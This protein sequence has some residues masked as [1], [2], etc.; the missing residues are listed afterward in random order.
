MK[1]GRPYI[2]RAEDCNIPL[3][4]TYEFTGIT[5]ENAT[6]MQGGGQYVP[7]SEDNAIP[8]D[9]DKYARQSLQVCGAIIEAC[10]ACEDITALRLQK[11]DEVN[12]ANMLKID[13]RL[14]DAWA[15]LPDEFKDY[16]RKEVVDLPAIRGAPVSPN[17]FSEC[18]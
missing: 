15:K 5:A 3:P 14:E 16:N 8:L 7:I 2:L 18:Y 4:G 6:S 17:P 9:H 10:K 12:I 1:L 13:K 11:D